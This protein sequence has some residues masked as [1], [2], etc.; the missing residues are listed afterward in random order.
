LW[1]ERHGL[2]P[3]QQERREQLRSDPAATAVANP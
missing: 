1:V 3:R 2:S